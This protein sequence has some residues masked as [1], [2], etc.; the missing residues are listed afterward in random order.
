MARHAAVPSSISNDF[1]LGGMACCIQHSVFDVV[2]VC[3]RVCGWRDGSGASG[4]DVSRS[5]V[6]H[7]SEATMH[8]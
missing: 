1:D 5:G 3:A 6:L 2:C 4:G 8:S 7:A